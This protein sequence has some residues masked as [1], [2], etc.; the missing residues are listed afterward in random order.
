MAWIIS[1]NEVHSKLGEVIATFTYADESNP[2]I[3]KVELKFKDPKLQC[4]NYEI[5]GSKAHQFLAGY[6]RGIN[7]VY[8]KKKVK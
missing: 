4:F 5:V 7:V 1:K 2:S 8:D 6:V 3:Q